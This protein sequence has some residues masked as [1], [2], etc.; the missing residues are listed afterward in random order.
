MHLGGNHFHGVSGRLMSDQG[1]EEHPIGHRR[2]RWSFQLTNP[3]LGVG[4]APRQPHHD[5]SPRT[6]G[7]ESNS[8]YVCLFQM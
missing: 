6:L 5:P 8:P 4:Q 7:L 2:N 3:D 1:T